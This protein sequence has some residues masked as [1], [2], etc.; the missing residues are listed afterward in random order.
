MI[1][2]LTADNFKLFSHALSVSGK[3]VYILSFLWQHRCPSADYDFFTEECSVISNLAL[4][5]CSH[6][7]NSRKLVLTF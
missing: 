3:M 5:W 6:G 2:I 1:T 4:T 7:S